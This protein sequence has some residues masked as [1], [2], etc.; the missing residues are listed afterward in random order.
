MTIP[1]ME[2][3]QGLRLS[4]PLSWISNQNHSLS[5]VCWNW[6]NNIVFV[7]CNTVTASQRETLTSIVY[8]LTL[9][10]THYSNLQMNSQQNT[11]LTYS[12]C[13][14]AGVI[15]AAGTKICNPS[16]GDSSCCCMTELLYSRKQLI[17]PL[18]SINFFSFPGDAWADRKWKRLGSL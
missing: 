12:L 8:S 10:N 1:L 7:L 3:I 15:N 11:S 6:P 5:F 16:D 9:P 4:H 13:V 14:W 2:M 17:D 18:T